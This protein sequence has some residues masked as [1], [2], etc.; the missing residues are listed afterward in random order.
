MNT[1]GEGSAMRSGVFVLSK[2]AKA[3]GVNAGMS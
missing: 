1:E 3:R 2:D